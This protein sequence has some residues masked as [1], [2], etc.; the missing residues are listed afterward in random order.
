M[1]ECIL[2]SS[3]LVTSYSFPRTDTRLPLLSSRPKPRPPSWLKKS[4]TAPH[5]HKSP[6]RRPPSSPRSPIVPYP[7]SCSRARLTIV[8]FVCRPNRTCR[9]GLSTPGTPLP[10]LAQKRSR[11]RPKQRGKCARRRNT[12]RAW[13]STPHPRLT[14]VDCFPLS[15]FLVDDEGRPRPPDSGTRRHW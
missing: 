14:C 11:R 5:K 7:L 4:I 3:R 9:V 2:C 6:Q 1:S 10:P 12:Q 8:R 13:R 15:R